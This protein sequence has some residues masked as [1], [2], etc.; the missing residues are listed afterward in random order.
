MKKAIVYIG[1][2]LSLISC[3]EL[4][5]WDQKGF[6]VPRLVVEAFITNQPGYNYVKLRS[7]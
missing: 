2:F 5:E 4:I 3:E 7:R 1:L 6:F